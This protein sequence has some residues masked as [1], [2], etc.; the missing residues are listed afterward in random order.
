M[1]MN[2]KTTNYVGIVKGLTNQ[3]S[4]LRRKERK[5]SKAFEKNEKTFYEEG[6]RQA[7]D[8]EYNELIEKIAAE[9]NVIKVKLAIYKIAA[10]RNS[11]KLSRSAKKAGFLT[12]DVYA[13]FEKEKLL[14]EYKITLETELKAYNN[15][16]FEEENYIECSSIEDYIDYEIKRN[17]DNMNPKQASKIAKR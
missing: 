3:Y 7:K 5:L 14:R 12:N 9:Q 6:E 16:I 17:S 15:S 13:D 4:E 2:R 1:Q 11:S 8:V 10:L